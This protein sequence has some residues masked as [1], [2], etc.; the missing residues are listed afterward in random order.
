[1]ERTLIKDLREKIGQTVMMEGWLQTLRDQ[2]KIQFLILR[3]PPGWRRWHIGNPMMK[4]WQKPSRKIG[5]ESALQHY[6]QGGRQSGGKT[7][8]AGSPA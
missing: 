2:K 8:W 1:M 5:V 3:D 6:R 4:P 7:E